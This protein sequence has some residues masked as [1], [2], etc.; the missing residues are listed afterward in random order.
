MN[1]TGYSLDSRVKEIQNNQNDKKNQSQ[2][3]L[4]VNPFEVTSSFMFD[5]NSAFSIALR[6]STLETESQ[7]S[8]II[9]YNPYNMTD[10]DDKENN[11]KTENNKKCA[12]IKSELKIC[13]N[14]YKE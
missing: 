4:T 6:F 7:W 11:E 3:I 9:K 8:N 12:I 2:Y 14:I 5:Q 1:K 10:S 13:T